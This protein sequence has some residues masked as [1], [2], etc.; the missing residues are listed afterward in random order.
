L[1]PDERDEK[2]I[3]AAKLTGAGRTG[4]A[5]GGPSGPGAGPALEA[6]RALLARRTRELVEAVVL[7]DVA[8]V[9]LGAVAAEIGSLAERLGAQRPGPIGPEAGPDWPRRRP[10]GPVT[11]EAN[12][13][14]PPIRITTTPEGTARAEFSLGPV[15]EGPPGAV[16]GGVCAAVLDSLLGAAAAAGQRPG[17]TAKLILSYL[18]PT[19]LSVPL[20][21]EAWITGVDRRTTL[22]DG[23]ILNERGELT[24]EATGE[25][26]LPLHW[27]RRGRA[28]DR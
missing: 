19:P 15:Y 25:F 17:M 24:V 14:A 5:G 11:G 27:Q 21:A 3:G 18:R 4:D 9:E 7:S 20:V 13:L 16:H 6:A 26:S 2:T 1:S 22:V 8:I 10:R 28:A 12:P 23:R